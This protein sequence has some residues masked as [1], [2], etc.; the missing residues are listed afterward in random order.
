MS[1][2]MTPLAAFFVLSA[3]GAAAAL[4]VPAERNPPVLSAFGA[5]SSA[6]LLFAGAAGLLSGSSP[7]LTY[8]HFLPLGALRLGLDP[9]SSLLVL[10]T[11]AIGFPVSIFSGTYLLRYREEYDL[12][13]FGLLYH[14]FLAAIVFVLVARDVFSFLVAWEAMSVLAYLLVTYEND[15]SDA[16]HAGFVMLAM[17][18]AG[19]ILAAGALL[20]LANGAGSIDFTAIR[21]AAPHLNPGIRWAVFLLSFAGFAV[22][23]GLVPVNSWLPLAHPVAPT[24]VSAL[25]SAVMVNLGIYGIVL[26]NLSLMPLHGTAPGALVL[27]VGSLSAL[28]GILYATIE[29]ELKRLLAHSTIENMG[30]VTAALGAAMIFLAA[31][32]K[33]PAALALLAAFYHLTNH[34]LYKALLFTG[35]GAAQTGSG[36]RDLDRMGGLIHR[37]PMTAIFFLAGVMA[38]AA[39]PPFNGFVSEWLTLQSILR[40]T[41]LASK[42]LRL[43]F[44]L[45]GA[46]LALTAGLAMTCFVKVFAMGFL[47]L[48]RSDEA[49]GAVEAPRAMRSAMALLTAACLLLGILPTYAIPLLD[50]VVKELGGSSATGALVQ[51]FFLVGPSGGQ[52]LSAQFVRDFHAIGAQVGKG[53]LPGRGLVILLRGAAQNPVVFAISPTYGVIAFPIL[54]GLTFVVFRLATRGR[55]VARRAVWVGGLGRLVP[56]LTYTA[57]G[58][59]NPVRVVFRAVLRPTVTEHVTEEVSEVFRPMVRREQIETH[60]VD[61]FLLGPAASGLRRLAGLLRRMHSG[62]VNLY[63]SYVL[64][65]LLLA[66]AI[67]AGSH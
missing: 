26:V 9:L 66:F 42:P 52:G 62:S 53:L 2:T 64:L 37:M 67:W 28:I 38:I 13:Y 3:I 29:S 11:G 47:G 49:A 14:L 27:A 34:S 4:L 31:G 32:E 55:R 36:T 22:K 12:G 63:A 46:L 10:L 35:T 39:L 16:A 58:F 65:T 57:S 44:A 43:L 61:R 8:W 30:I 23:A 59:A 21:A 5:A 25:L 19:M 56:A 40:S 7:S 24:N 41:L 54:L 60:V 6:A 45:S 17:S 50:H 51:P 33:L 20:L 15:K 18:E 1:L 48:P